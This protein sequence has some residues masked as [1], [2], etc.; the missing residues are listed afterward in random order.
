LPDDAD[1]EEPEEYIE[2]DSESQEAAAEL[3]LEDD[4]VQ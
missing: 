4:D 2:D 1:Y 3:E